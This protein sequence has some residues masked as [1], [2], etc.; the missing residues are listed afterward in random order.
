MPDITKEHPFLNFHTENFFRK[1]PLCNI[2][3]D[4]LSAELR[5]FLIAMNSQMDSGD[6][7]SRY[8][9]YSHCDWMVGHGL[10]HSRDVWVIANRF[11]DTYRDTNL[12]LND[13]EKYCLCCAI[14]LHDIGMS[15][16]MAHILPDNIRSIR[17]LWKNSTKTELPENLT[18]IEIRKYHSFIS[19]YFI[20]NPHGKQNPINHINAELRT[21]IAL[22]C[23]YH[24]SKWRF[25]NELVNTD[26]LGTLTSETIKDYSLS[27]GFYRTT[28]ELGAID[29]NILYLSALL[30]FFDE[31]DQITSRIKDEGPIQDQNINKLSQKHTNILEQLKNCSNEIIEFW[32]ECCK[33]PD[34]YTCSNE[35]SK[36][37]FL[38][39]EKRLENQTEDIINNTLYEEYK[40]ISIETHSHFIAKVILDIG[41]TANRK[42]AIQV[43]TTDNRNEI[44]INEFKN[45]I[46]RN[47]EICQRFFPLNHGINNSNPISFFGITDDL[48]IPVNRDNRVWA[49][50]SPT[51]VELRNSPTPENEH[52]KDWIANLTELNFLNKKQL[53]PTEKFSGREWLYQKIN[54]H[55]LHP[56]KQN[57]NICVISA[58]KGFG[59]THFSCCCESNIKNF[60]GIFICDTT[61]SFTC[62]PINWINSIIKILSDSHPSFKK[63]F[64]QVSNESQIFNETRP[65]PYFNEFF[66]RLNLPDDLKYKHFVFVLDGLDEAETMTKENSGFRNLLEM[67]NPPDFL[68]FLITKRPDIEIYS[69]YSRIC[70]KN[71][72]FDSNSNQNDLKTY[73]EGRIAAIE[74]KGKIPKDI[75]QK[76]LAKLDEEA[77]GNFL[78]AK[79]V[80]D[81]TEKGYVFL[82]DT[83]PS[84][85]NFLYTAMLNNRFNED[86]DHKSIRPVLTKLCINKRIPGKI[87][88]DNTTDPIFLKL[89]QFLNEYTN[90]SGHEYEFF[91]ESFKRWIQ[92]EAPD[93]YK[94]TSEEIKIKHGEIALLCNNALNVPQTSAIESDYARKNILYHLLKSE[95][96]EDALKI[97]Q[98]PAYIMNRCEHN[99]IFEV[100]EDLE[101]YQKNNADDKNLNQLSRFFTSRLHVL[102]KYPKIISQEMNNFG[103]DVFQNTKEIEGPWL[104]LENKYSTPYAKKFDDHGKT[105]QKI[106]IVDGY[107]FTAGGNPPTNYISIWD[108]NRGTYSRLCTDNP[109]TPSI[110]DS[111]CLST[112]YA[113]IA[114]DKTDTNAI[115][116][117]SQS[118]NQERISTTIPL[119]RNIRSFEVLNVK[120]T[121]NE[122][123]VF[124]GYPQNFIKCFRYNTSS[125]NISE[126]Q[127][128]EYAF[129]SQTQHINDITVSEILRMPDGDTVICKGIPSQS[130]SKQSDYSVLFS[131]H[132][133][134]RNIISSVRLDGKLSC[135]KT[136]NRAIL[137]GCEDGNVGIINVN[138]GILSQE[139]ERKKKLHENKV[140]SI[141]SVQDIYAESSDV[142]GKIIRWQI[143]PIIQLSNYYLFSKQP[144]D[145]LVIDS[146]DNQIFS[147]LRHNDLRFVGA[148]GVIIIGRALPDGDGQFKFLDWIPAHV[149]AVTNLHLYGENFLISSSNDGTIKIWDLSAILN[150]DDIAKTGRSFKQKV[151]LI[152]FSQD[153]RYCFFASSPLH[154]N[155]YIKIWDLDTGVP[156]FVK[157]IAGGGGILS[158]KSLNTTELVACEQNG[159]V[160]HGNFE[161]RDM[162]TTIDNSCA[163]MS[164]ISILNSE[165]GNVICC[166][167]EPC[168]IRILDPKKEKLEN[169]EI[170]Y[171]REPNDE[172][173]RVIFNHKGEIRYISNPERYLRDVKEY[174]QNNYLKIAFCTEE[175]G[176]DAGKLK[177]FDYTTK[178]L[179]VDLTFNKP[180]DKIFPVE[181][182]I[183]CPSSTGTVY[184]VNTN[185]ENENIIGSSEDN[186]P[187][188][189]SILTCNNNM[190][191]FY[192]LS[193]NFEFMETSLYKKDNNTI[194][195]SGTRTGI[196]TNCLI[197]IINSFKLGTDI[198]LII[199]S[200]DRTLTIW[201]RGHPNYCEVAKFY[202]ESEI[203][204]C[205]YHNYQKKPRIICGGTDGR[206][207]FISLEN[208]QGC[209]N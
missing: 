99:E 51:E 111:S 136:I 152:E 159:V 104:R 156:V 19:R 13:L 116:D 201:K 178:K 93:I 30:R 62:N 20:E 89:K 162:L 46:K 179:E 126:Y 14:W 135:I 68:K 147:M 168:T 11:F 86:V 146:L 25:H 209:G 131:F 85:L 72:P 34:I 120:N 4:Q 184:V 75:R 203:A 114:P 167:T 56:E 33:P 60:A 118:L 154:K 141:I 37:L 202:S 183:I 194:G 161:N 44:P 47:L 90:D 187:D 3:N 127:E 122:F 82:G 6:V 200:S 140:T 95:K 58:G 63:H 174:F 76:L 106:C 119:L 109:N 21:C 189:F 2:T 8:Y 182:L 12:Q 74:Q 188:I 22:I 206:I 27:K 165:T 192:T 108:I 157:D 204:S 102:L 124:I 139:P 40:Y 125:K 55:F 145:A 54:N 181:N 36:S 15:T 65:V 193:R 96:Y 84:N 148:N 185:T 45:G 133:V 113:H 98:N 208:F 170:F 35:E 172:Q 160:R 180:L 100:M 205:S 38:E 73:V 177:V 132:A 53:Y 123:T 199:A 130:D 48:F 164:Y 121:P 94:I 107:I 101:E 128:I 196:T 81:D 61:D 175:K 134:N 41:F 1:I 190:I 31:C 83:L 197:N 169:V 87:L 198:Y 71:L 50:S 16:T 191:Y 42:I 117:R 66:N 173:L 149:K 32:R 64:Q 43:D 57:Q 207:Y 67:M 143:N 138:E 137:Y 88:I 92:T 77:S 186:F 103:P 80:L 155:S 24:Q 18:K 26:V 17:N 7:R 78:Y 70:H 163:G 28:S 10:Q 129:S 91:H 176:T 29:I 153:G 115:P 110:Q 49:V 151:D 112:N 69:Y 158:I 105:I 150:K 23:C 59:K 79:L 5:A 171:P 166:G 142:D 144:R 195:I 39:F 52:E 9:G 97:L